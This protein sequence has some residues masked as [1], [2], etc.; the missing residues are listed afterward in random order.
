VPEDLWQAAYLLSGFARCAV[1]GGGL[2][3]TSSQRKGRRAFFYACTGYHKRGTSVCGDGL[4]LPIE[5]V[6]QACSARSAA[7]SFEKRLFNE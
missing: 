4:I 1:C 7:K 2:G 3:V 6:D 5:R